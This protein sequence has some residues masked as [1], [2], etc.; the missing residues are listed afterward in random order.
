MLVMCGFRHQAYESGA[1]CMRRLWHTLCA[2]NALNRGLG[3]GTLSWEC[4]DT[5]HCHGS[6]HTARDVYRFDDVYSSVRWAYCYE[7]MRSTQ[8]IYGLRRHGVRMYQ[9]GIQQADDVCMYV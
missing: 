7:S 2:A 1:W 8:N 6:V 4:A 3:Y 5:A 9:D